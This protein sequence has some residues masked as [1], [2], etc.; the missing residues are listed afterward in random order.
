MADRIKVQGFVPSDRRDQ[1]EDPHIERILERDRVMP[2]APPLPET[3]DG[4]DLIVPAIRFPHHKEPQVPSGGVESETSRGPVGLEFPGLEEN[5]SA[6]G[7]PAA[8]EIPQIVNQTVQSPELP[9]SFGPGP[10]SE[11]PEIPQFNAAMSQPLILPDRL[12]QRDD[13]ARHSVVWMD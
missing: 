7:Q 8:P 12:T 11:L 4:V 10:H 9:D 3:K 5:S 2:V 6:R 1:P 13:I